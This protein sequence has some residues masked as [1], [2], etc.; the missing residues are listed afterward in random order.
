MPNKAK[1]Y[2]KIIAV[3]IAVT[4]V[5]GYAYYRTSDLID[6]PQVLI[7]TP[8]NGKTIEESFTLI[9]GRTQNISDITLNGRHI[10]TDEAGKIREEALLT[11]GLNVF[12][13][14]A[15]DRFG[16]EI[17]KVLEVVYK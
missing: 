3:T 7:E 11:Y 5:L 1:L 12:E 13:I 15:R 2:L 9:E 8:Q 10:F 6:G 17:T 4:S 16:R 14:R